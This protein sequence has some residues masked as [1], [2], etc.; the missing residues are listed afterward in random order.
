MWSLGQWSIPQE[1]RMEVMTQEKESKKE[2]LFME[3]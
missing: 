1:R 3:C 2:T